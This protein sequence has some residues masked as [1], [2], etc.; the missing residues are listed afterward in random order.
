MLIGR[1]GRRFDFLTRSFLRLPAPN[2]SAD[3]G[4]LVM[5]PTGFTESPNGF[6][7]LVTVSFSAFDEYGPLLG[8][9]GDFTVC[10]HYVGLLKML[11]C[12]RAPAL[13]T[14]VRHQQPCPWSRPQKNSRLSFLSVWKRVVCRLDQ[15]FE[16]LSRD[17]EATAHRYNR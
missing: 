9:T 17:T 14:I 16:S 1:E 3:T 10:Y 7:G 12:H 13:S 2:G 6:T 5:R 11:R 8:A 4:Q 15:G